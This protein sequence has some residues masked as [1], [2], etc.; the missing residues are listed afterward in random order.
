MSDGRRE[1]VRELAI[2]GLVSAGH[3]WSHFFTLAI[4]TALPL[5]RSDLG[6][7]NVSLGMVMAAFALMAAAWQF[8]MGVLSDRYGARVFL[9]G[10]LAIE[11]LAMF[12][13]SLAPAVP[14][15]VAIALVMGIADSV[16]HPADYT[17]LTAKI[18]QPWLGRA[19]AVHTFSGFLGFAAAPTVMSLLIAYGNWRQALAVVGAAGFATALVLLASG[20]LLSGISYPPKRAAGSAAGGVASLLLS[21]PLLIMFL[22]YVV[23]TFSSNG[24]QNFGNS[25]LIALYDL[26]I[27]GANAA[28]AA[29]LWGTAI[30][31]LGGGLVADSMKRFDAIA[32]VCY[33]IAGVLLCLIGIAALP[34]AGIVAALF[35]TGFMLGAVM[36][37]R[38]MMVRTVTPP[39]SIGKAFGYVS[40]G[41]GVGGVIGPLVYGSMMDFSMPQLLFFVS[42]G[43]MLA[44]IAVALL[45]SYV[46]RRTGFRM[47]PAG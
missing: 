41:F 12:S 4:P 28:L 25:A 29:F 34:Y 22:F 47:Q 24:L 33:L 10:G 46:A 21:P 42:A 17:V 1:K 26:D 32:T 30:G 8:P 15:M 7:S 6:A 27:V 13:Q 35:F 2:V 16:F 23:A 20:K 5:I 43:M 18:R 45:A 3:F 37:A 14:V 19:Y 31:V 9:V 40:S 39:G 44:T 38:D 11:S 36:P